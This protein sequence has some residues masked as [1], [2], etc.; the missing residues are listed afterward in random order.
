MR[1]PKK[2]YKPKEQ[3][4]EG[5]YRPANSLS[6]EQFT[7]IC[8]APSWDHRKQCITLEVL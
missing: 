1:W 8:K 4:C 3:N 6:A 5:T 7:Y 2:F